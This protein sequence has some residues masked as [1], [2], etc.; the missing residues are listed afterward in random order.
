MLGKSAAIITTEIGL[1][2]YLKD[3]QIAI[4]RS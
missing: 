4:K 3:H 2:F 1:H